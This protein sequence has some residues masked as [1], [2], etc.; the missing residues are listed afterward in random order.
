MPLVAVL[1]EMERRGVRVD[2]GRLAALA[3]EY[4]TRLARLMADIHALAGGEFNVHSPPQLREVLF[5]RLGLSSRGVRRGKTGLSTDVDVLRRLAHEHPLPAAILEYRA[6]AKLKSTYVD[7]LPALIDP[8]TGRIHT[9]YN[10]AVTATGRLS[11]SDP[12]LQNI[13]VRGEEGRRIRAAFTA[14]PGRVLLSADYSQIELRVLAHLSGDP[15]LVDAF[16]RGEDVHARTAAEV[17][18]PLFGAT[19]DARRVAKVI[20]FG[21]IYGMGAARLARELEI[22]PDEAARYIRSYFERYAG[23]RAYIERT[24]AEARERGYVST[25]LNRRRYLPELRS[26]EGAARQFAERTAINTPVQGSAADLIKLAMLRVHARIAREGL[27]A[28]MTVQVH[29]E[30]VFEVAGPQLEAAAALVRAEMEGVVELAVPLRVD[31]H[32]GDSWAEAH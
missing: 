25:L 23:V 8:A 9:S 21:V 15:T 6:L 28:W 26:R 22:P 14:E 29:D 12:N 24:V 16:R 11:S 1:A 17:F 19:A 13:P 18:G 30:L 20:N 5:Q 31:A 2:A 7:A 4:E 32:S 3:A 10:Q 27:D